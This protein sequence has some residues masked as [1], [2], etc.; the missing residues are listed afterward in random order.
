M[1]E[2]GRNEQNIVFQD[3]NVGFQNNLPIG[4]C[5][6]QNLKKNLCAKNLKL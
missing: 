6:F 1:N 3:S 5:M 4:F 2:G